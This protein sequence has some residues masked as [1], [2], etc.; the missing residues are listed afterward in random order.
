MTPVRFSVGY[1]IMDGEPDY[2]SDIVEDHA[3]RVAEV[4][5]AWPGVNSGRSPLDEDARAQLEWE[6]GRITGWGIGL[7]LLLNASCFGEEACSPALVDRLMAV[8]DD[9]AARFG[10]RAVTTMS[11]VIGHAVKERHPEIDLRASVNMRLGT[12]RGMA[13]V[14]DL[15]DSYCVQREF[16]RDGARLAALQRWAADNGKRLHVLANS[17]CMNYCS[18]QTFHDNA[19]AHESAIH[20][21]G[22]LADSQTLCRSYLAESAHWSNLLSGSS[23]IRPEDIASHRRVFAGGYKL[24]TRA[25]DDPRRV[26]EA[27]VRG[28]HRGNLLDLLEPGLGPALYPRVLDNAAFGTD[29]FERTMSCAGECAS[30]GYCER[31]LKDVLVDVEGALASRLGIPAA[32]VAR[33]VTSS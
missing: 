22:R 27:Y 18:F 12:V 4:Y 1:R 3:R 14:A 16:N 20:T 30:C 25:H 24:A 7:N 5:F 32:D 2:F 17:G 9:V 6:L 28:S 13:Y 26:I 21:R 33:A 29:W 23:W 11:P 31:K 15:Y 10:V 19:V 8:V